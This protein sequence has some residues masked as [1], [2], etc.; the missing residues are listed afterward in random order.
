LKTIT[1]VLESLFLIKKNYLA[2]FT[3]YAD[4]FSA[5]LICEICKISEKYKKL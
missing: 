5:F 2:A 4:L 3:D 1:Q